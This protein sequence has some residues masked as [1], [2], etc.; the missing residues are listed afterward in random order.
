MQGVDY[1]A[2]SL[3]LPVA[4][5]KQV[6][7]TAPPVDPDPDPE[8]A[9]VDSTAP[10]ISGFGGTRA[11][12]ALTLWWRT[13]EPATSE[14][15]F[16]GYGLFGDDSTYVTDHELR[17]TINLNDSYRFRVLSSDAAGNT[18]DSGWYTSSP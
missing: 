13:D 1:W 7:L 5:L 8:A 15:E 16:D 17:F 4:A 11:T 6:T 9:P 18:S 10:V 3:V 2:F 14:I 12:T